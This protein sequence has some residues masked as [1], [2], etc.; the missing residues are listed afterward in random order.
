MAFYAQKNPKFEWKGPHAEWLKAQI[1][2][3][4]AKKHT[5]IN[6]PPNFLEP[7]G[8]V[9]FAVYCI[10]V[11]LRPHT[12]AYASN[13]CICFMNSLV[14]NSSAYLYQNSTS[15]AYF[16]A[17]GIVYSQET[18]A[19]VARQARRT[20][21]WV[22][23][24][25]RQHLSSKKQALSAKIAEGFADLVALCSENPEFFVFSEKLLS[26]GIYSLSEL[27]EVSIKQLAYFKEMASQNIELTSRAPLIVDII[28]YDSCV[29]I[30]IL[31]EYALNLA[32]IGLPS[33]PAPIRFVRDPTLNDLKNSIIVVSVETALLGYTM[34]DSLT[35]MLA[36][37]RH[38]IDQTL[39]IPYL[40]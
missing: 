17:T 36:Q 40:S 4:A 30:E 3:E 12:I 39:H 11:A 2:Q 32:Q 31:L 10:S 38:C 8:S 1:Y 7:S 33:V 9:I 18:A 16:G 37:K 13:A 6:L 25:L 21:L 5:I 22:L 23:S 15:N 19:F 34:I 26:D 29:A 14:G 35:R 27:C 24:Q 20:R 28:F